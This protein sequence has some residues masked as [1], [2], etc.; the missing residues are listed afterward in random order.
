MVDRPGTRESEEVYRREAMG[1]FSH[2][3]RTPLTSIRMVMEL[4]R[5]E[6]EEGALLLDKELATMLQS[7]VN[8]LERL[9]D[10]LQEAS[11]IE[12]GKLAVSAGPC[13]L[14]AAF[15]AAAELLAPKITLTGDPIPDVEGPWDA[16]RVVRAL[17]GFAESANRIGDGSGVVHYTFRERPKSWQITIVS[18][19]PGGAAKELAADASFGFFRS[20]LFILAI[21]GKVSWQRAERYFAITV[22]LS[23]G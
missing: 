11:R 18:G 3:I 7:S 9:S 5:R 1:A 4:A 16:P 21:G 23:R 13:H 19:V 17:A 22:D 20:R 8:D 6:A 10:D 2:E 14:P 15:A 12:R